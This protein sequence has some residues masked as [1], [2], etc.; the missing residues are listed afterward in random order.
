MQGVDYFD[1]NIKEAEKTARRE[2]LTKLVSFRKPFA[3]SLPF[4][5]DNTTCHA[6]TVP[7]LLRK[8]GEG[9]SECIRVLKPVASLP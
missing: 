4:E 8:Q 9:L 1:G 2:K 6:G 7:L 5:D 3:E